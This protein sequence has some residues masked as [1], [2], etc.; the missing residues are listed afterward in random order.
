MAT[1]AE[2]MSH[3]R[4]YSDIED[5][6]DGD[7]KIDWRLDS[8]RSQMVVM[9]VLDTVLIM[10]SP[11][12]K[13][14]DITAAKALGLA[15]V[16]GIAKIGEFYTFRHVVLMEDLDQS[17]ISNALALVAGLADKAEAEVGGDRF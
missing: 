1:R 2:V 6:G 4:S 5:L 17:E 3:L 10:D 7:F 9:K 13:E 16:F 14:D 11:Y 8:G 12:A 15:K